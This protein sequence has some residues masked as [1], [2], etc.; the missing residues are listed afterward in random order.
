[1]PTPEPQVSVVIPTYNC[2]AYL[3]EAVESVLA[4]TYRDFE[5][6][7]ID[8]G[9]TD[10]TEAMMRRY[11]PPVRYFRQPNRGVALARNHGIEQSRGR[12]V[13]FLDADDTWMPQKLE[14][15]LV[16]LAGQPAY[17]ACYSAFVTMTSDRRP[18]GVRRSQRRGSVW[19]DLLL[20][21]N[22]IGTPSTV[23]CERSLALAAGGFDPLLSLGADWDMW[24]RLGALTEFLYVDEPLVW[25]REHGANMSRDAALLERDS[26][27]VLQ[28]GF[29]MA[30]LPES[31]RMQRR[32]AFARNYMVLAGTYF[33]ARRYGDFLRCAARAV[34]LD[35][36]QAS[37]LAA[38]PLRWLS[39][40]RSHLGSEIG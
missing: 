5:V 35:V 37:Y 17:R 3:G 26:L 10:E 2:A 7:V 33:H 6:V 11:G 28:K 40:R 25:Y 32:A 18:L 39:R 20:Y 23:L 12:Y 36:K 31:L 1:M 29:A 13:A 30:A 24:I 4:Q 34:A 16:A 14:R 21:G 27:R 15:Q 19:H 38:F 9:S 22:L 8:D